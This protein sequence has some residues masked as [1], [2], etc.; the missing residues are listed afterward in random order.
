MALL[1]NDLH[2][3]QGLVDLAVYYCKKYHVLLSTEKTKLQVYSCKSSEIEAFLAQAT[4][5]LNMDGKPLQF[6][7]EAEHVGVLRSTA[8]NLP[9]LLSRFVSHR[10]AMFGILPLGIAKANR[11]NP[12]ASL[13][14]HTT[15]CSPVFFSG[16]ATLLL[17]SSEVTMLDQH[18][19]VSIQRL[20]KLQDKTPHCA[21]MFLGGHLPGKAQLHLRI[22]SLFGMVSRLQDTFLNKIAV[23]QFLHVNVHAGSWFLQVR[24][25]CIQYNLPSPIT[26]LQ[27]PLNKYS[28]KKLIKSRVIDFW[29][30]HLRAEALE[31]REHSL[32]YF[33]A[34]FM[35]LSKPHLLWS[36]CGSNPYEIHKSVIQARMLSGR[37]ITDQLSRHWTGNKLGLCSIPGCSGQEFGSLEHILLSCPALS[38]ARH[39]ISLL[40]Q[41]VALECED[42]RAVLQTALNDQ[43]AELIVQ[44]I[45]DCSSLPAVIL[46]NQNGGKHLV[47]RLFYIGRTWCY[48][49]HRSRMNKLGL[50]QYR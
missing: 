31:L 44:F 3:L 20:Q 25:I 40:I 49:V 23:H 33:K 17:N 14:A 4:S 15:Y 21:V 48:S 1:S 6:V 37:Y 34:E 27:H 7:D 2:A 39:R 12:A 42:F 36:T 10:K 47:E 28:Y 13:R 11:G 24:N 43:T 50:S 46:L 22:L 30:T 38:E 41:K 19:K 5:L 35:S 32:K 45:L 8:G 16:V 18:Y 29:E 9:H 26:L